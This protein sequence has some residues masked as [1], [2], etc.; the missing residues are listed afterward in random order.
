MTTSTSSSPNSYAV[1][2]INNDEK[3]AEVQDELMRFVMGATMNSNKE[4]NSSLPSNKEENSNVFKDNESLKTDIDKLETS[5]QKD[6]FSVNESNKSKYFI[7]NF[8]GLINQVRDKLNLNDKLPDIT[9]NDLPEKNLIK[10][11]EDKTR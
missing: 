6:N 4:Q 7:N 3:K 1:S 5:S 11:A 9:P 10:K 2:Q 8:L